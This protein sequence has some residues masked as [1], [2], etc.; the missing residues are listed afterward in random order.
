MT[1]TIHKVTWSDAD[2]TALRDAQE[3]EVARRYSAPVTG[4]GPE[5]EGLIAMLVATVDGQ[6]A[7]CAAVVEVTGL[8][9]EFGEGRTAEVR[10][11]Y[12]DP[13]FRGHGLGRALLDVLHDEARAADMEQLVLVSGT[14]QPES[15]ALYRS[16][17][18]L[19]LEPYGFNKQ[20]ET[21]LFFW[22][23]L[24]SVALTA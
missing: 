5:P 7:G 11:V 2:A 4:S 24:Q 15:V 14:M 9:P 10:R 13:Q 19:P 17:G 18:Y 22:L 12:V 21:S 23:P 16:A 1:M 6:P 20:F 8:E 3:A